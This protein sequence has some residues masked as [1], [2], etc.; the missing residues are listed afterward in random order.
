M[1]R[2]VQSFL[3]RGRFLQG[4][5]TSTTSLLSL[6]QPRINSAFLPSSP[7]SRSSSCAHSFSTTSLRF[8]PA[9]EWTPE[10][11]A[12][13]LKLREQGL[14]WK[15]VAKALDRNYATCYNRYRLHLQLKDTGFWTPARL[16]TLALQPVPWDVV[17]REIQ[18]LQPKTKKKKGQGGGKGGI[19]I[20]PT[21]C[22]HQWRELMGRTTGRDDFR[23]PLP[24]K[25]V[26]ALHERLEVEKQA[27]RR[28]QQGKQPHTAAAITDADLDLSKLD[29]KRITRDIFKN[30]VTPEHVQN[31][32][33]ISIRKTHK[34]TDA[35][36]EKLPEFVAAHTSAT[37]GLTSESWE[38]IASEFDNKHT[39]ME[40]RAKWEALCRTNV[41]KNI[42]SR[43]GNHWSKN[44]IRA[45]WRAWKQHGTDWNRI[46]EAVRSLSS[47][48]SVAVSMGKDKAEVSTSTLSLA[49]K[50]AEDCR[51]DFKHVITVSIP[52]MDELEKEVGELALTRQPRKHWTWTTEQLIK[53]EIAV[54]GI[55]GE[56]KTLAQAA[57]NMTANDWEKVARKVN[58]QVTGDQCRYRWGLVDKFSPSLLTPDLKQP[59]PYPDNDT[60]HA[61]QRRRT[62]LWTAEEVRGLKE[63]AES[64]RALSRIPLDFTRRTRDELKLERTN[65][66]IRKKTNQILGRSP[67]L[68]AKAAGRSGGGSDSPAKAA[69]SIF[70][71]DPDIIATRSHT[72]ILTG[73]RFRLETLTTSRY[74]DDDYNREEQQI[75]IQPSASATTEAGTR[76][77]PTRLVWDQKDTARLTELVNK[78]GEST[79]SWKL[80]SAELSY[81]VSKCQDRWRYMKRVA[82]ASAASASSVS[83]TNKK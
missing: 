70:K 49:D 71:V 61:R 83:A 25:D 65:T 66:E 1:L 51:L 43:S 3:G 52:M 62:R 63:A 24:L 54:R 32:I 46:A 7:T 30:R 47:P 8:Q 16:R 17:A 60:T 59:V 41:R 75:Q 2:S 28:K 69:L 57:R 40:C 67:G 31:H 11:D 5:T 4:P 26:A 80:I 45:Y 74:G 14:G 29:W 81:P 72:H 36:V 9:L 82:A 39:P 21:G 34:W 42:L 58:T 50:S 13:L 10:Q 23:K 48:L 79:L 64:I 22:Q 27:L 37:E 68:L 12:R 53:M 73:K 35:Q 15:A 77:I 44:E 55:T 76:T 33:A 78:Y 38:R 18:L 56:F 6:H 19:E 20:S